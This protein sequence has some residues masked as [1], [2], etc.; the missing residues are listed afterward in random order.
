MLRS[1]FSGVSGMDAN[2]EW[3]DTIGNDI[4]NINTT[5]YKSS[6]IQ[7]EDLLGQTLAGATAPTAT[8][9]GVDP[10]QIGLGVK[11]AGIET[12]FSQGTSEQ[13]GN[14]LDLSIQG[15]G[16]FIAQNG[17]QT[18]YTQAGSLELDADGNLVTPN[19]YLVQGW[20]ADDQGVINTSAPLGPLTI[21]SNQQIAANTTQAVTLGGNLASQ[22][23][24]APPGGGTG[25]G[26]ATSAT[27]YA[28]DGSKETLDLS[29][30]QDTTMPSGAPQG[31]ASAWTVQGALTE[32]GATP[33]Y[34]T[35][36]GAT[37]TLFFNASGNLVGYTDQNGASSTTS[38][39]FSLT[40]PD[41]TTG[42]ASGATQKFTLN[43]PSVTANASDDT[44]SVLSQDGNA[45]GSLQSYSI[46]S[47]GVIQGVFSNGQALDLGQIALANFANPDGLEKAGDTNFTATANSGLAQVG[48]AGTGSFGSIQAGT[49]EASNVDLATEMTELIEAQNGFEANGSVISTSNTLLQALVNLK[50]GG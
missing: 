24:W 50:N 27:V 18:L 1:L 31:A 4:S 13:T 3:I 17:N 6:E 20:P 16:F 5:G 9:G 34:A 44:I 47:N 7:F 37:A 25:T 14:P 48:V 11:V 39:S 21:P 38:T 43:L 49:L 30:E 36:A 2:Q 46:G 41:Q 40:V 32:P 15:N 28:A 35:G 33:T 29:F 8:Q 45:P 10:T 12:D 26:T 22:A 19:G 42:A 23:G